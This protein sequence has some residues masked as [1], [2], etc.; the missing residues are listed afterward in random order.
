MTHKFD[1]LRPELHEWHMSFDGVADYAADLYPWRKLKYLSQELSIELEVV[2]TTLTSEKLE[3][4]VTRLEVLG[5]PVCV[6]VSVSY[7]SKLAGKLPT[8]LANFST[9]FF[10]TKSDILFLHY[11]LGKAGNVRS[12]PVGCVIIRGLS[13][14]RE[15]VRRGACDGRCMYN[16]VI[17]CAISCA[18]ATY[19]V[20]LHGRAKSVASKTMIIILL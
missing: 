7:R 12:L 3:R 18:C 2:Q 16:D 17:T 1:W 13:T 6:C 20:Q 4:D 5:E 10:L 19:A 14:I 15:Q 9:I 8:Y 11:S